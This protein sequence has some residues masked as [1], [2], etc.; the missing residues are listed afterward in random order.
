MFK[1]KSDLHE[2]SI[3][4]FKFNHYLNYAVSFAKWLP[5]IFNPETLDL[6]DWL[7]LISDTDLLQLA[8]TVVL[9]VE[10]CPEF[11]AVFCID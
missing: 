8:D 1:V 7:D 6:P 3:T 10:F 5:E 4:Y 9:S 2:S 11:M